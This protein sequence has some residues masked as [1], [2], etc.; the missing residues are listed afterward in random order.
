MKA[1]STMSQAV[2]SAISAMSAALALLPTRLDTRAARVQLIATGLQ[3]SRLTA[4]AQITDSGGAGPARGLLQFERGGGVR[5]V[6]EH[7]ATSQLAAL[8]CKLRDV[9]AE[10][11]A[12]WA[13]LERDDVLAFGFGRLLLLADPKPLPAL[14]NPQAAWD[15][16]VRNWRPGK[17]HRETWDAFY[18]RALEAIK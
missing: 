18:W 8:L 16:Y 12:V 3:E 1:N 5:G 17:P 10:K 4:R 14:D 7:P 13:A 15:C 11:T 2:D 6:L 9:E